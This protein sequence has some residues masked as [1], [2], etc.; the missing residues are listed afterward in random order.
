MEYCELEGEGDKVLIWQG[1]QN[2]VDEVC[3]LDIEVLI[4]DL[5]PRKRSSIKYCAL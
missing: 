3:K 5:D 4:V 1:Q 2:G